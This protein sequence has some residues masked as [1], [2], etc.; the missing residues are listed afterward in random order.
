[1]TGPE[2][3]HTV[4]FNENSKNFSSVSIQFNFLSAFHTNC[5]FQQAFSNTQYQIIL[6]F[7][8]LTKVSYSCFNFT[9]FKFL[10]FTDD[11]SLSD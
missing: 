9:E 1:M 11:L 6:K 4:S 2:D 7:S 5:A 10:E 8:N 3:M